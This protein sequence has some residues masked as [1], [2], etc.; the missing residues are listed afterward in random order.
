MYDELRAVILEKLDMNKKGK[1]STRRTVRD[2]SLYIMI[3]KAQWYRRDDDGLG[4]V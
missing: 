4:K 2:G 1:R 3:R